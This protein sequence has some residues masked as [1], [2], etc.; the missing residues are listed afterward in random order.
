[1]KQI[2]FGQLK[3][4]NDYYLYC[5]SESRTMILTGHIALLGENRNV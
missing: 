2:P 3:L 4:K 5:F 1:M